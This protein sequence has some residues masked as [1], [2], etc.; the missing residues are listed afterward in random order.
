DDGDDLLAR[1]R[2]SAGAARATI[3]VTGETTAQAARRLIQRD[4]VARVAALNFASAKNPG[5]G[6]LGGAKAQEEDLARA[7]ALY[8]CLITQRAYSDWTRACG[9]MIYPDHIISSPGVPF[10]RDDR[11]DLLEDPFVCSILTAPAPNAGEA[12]RHGEPRDEVSRA[13]H[14]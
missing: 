2:A 14:D 9:S 4:G 3:E 6:F 1:S 7:S 12:A 10:F 5:G 13:L 11:L 8:A